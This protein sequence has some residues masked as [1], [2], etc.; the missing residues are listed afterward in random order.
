MLL[1][2]KERA[3]N[4]ARWRRLFLHI[5]FVRCHSAYIL[6][7]LLSTAAMCI[8]FPFYSAT[9]SNQAD[10]KIEK[11]ALKQQIL[12]FLHALKRSHF[13]PLQML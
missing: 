13:L 12:R 5:S 7:L 8:L 4:A 9:A 1:L 6:F 10:R 11:T 2:T 3:S